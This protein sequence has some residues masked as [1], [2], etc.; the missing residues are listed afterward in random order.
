MLQR[1]LIHEKGENYVDLTLAEAMELQELRF[2]RVTPTAKEGRWRVTD[3]SK[4]GV[5]VIGSLALHVV[6]KTPLENI[7]FMASL[8]GSQLN[9]ESKEVGNAADTALPIALAQA[10]LREVDRATRRGLIKGYREVHESASVMRGRWDVAGQLATRPGIPLPLEID[11]DDF[12]EDIDENRILATAVRLLRGIEGLPASTTAMIGRLGAQFAEVGTLPRGVAI[13]MPQP[14]Q[15]NRHYRVA[16]QLAQVILE[17]VSWTHRDGTY[18]G[19]A[20]LVDMAAVFEGYIANRLMAH[21]GVRGLEVTTQD[22]RWW[23]DADHAIALRPD[24]VI[25]QIGET[26]TAADTKYK[27]LGD[28]TGGIPNSDVYQA[29][30]YALALGVPEAH[31]I[32]VSGD[33]SARTVDVP[34][35]GVRIHA[36]AIPLAGSA[37]QIEHSVAGLCSVI[38]P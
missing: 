19:G 36:H 1:I 21:L 4:V 8:G 37:E 20:F 24:I 32:Y 22:R 9:L 35:A 5:A 23:L 12:T 10:F 3:V 29:V 6:P 18:H 31:L 15:L 17:A 26:V 16:L 7:V 38:V 14:T 13:S 27:V 33:V 30:A 25:S 34:T 11:F 28:G 2:C